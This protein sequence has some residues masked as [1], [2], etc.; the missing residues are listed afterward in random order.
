MY[1]PL[2]KI[3]TITIQPESKLTKEDRAFVDKVYNEQDI[4]IDKMSKFH[5]TINQLRNGDPDIDQLADDFQNSVKNIIEN[6]KTNCIHSVFKYFETKYNISLK[7]INPITMNKATGELWIPDLADYPQDLVDIRLKSKKDIL[8]LIFDE[9]GGLS[10]NEV[11][12]QN[13]IN[14]CRKLFKNSSDYEFK[15][16]R[17]SL[18]LIPYFIRH[19]KCGFRDDMWR[20]HSS[21]IKETESFFTALTHLECGMNKVHDKLWLYTTDK[22]NLD[23]DTLF[24]TQTFDFERIKALRFFKNGWLQIWFD[25]NATAERF[26]SVYMGR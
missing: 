2:E 6:A 17:K 7:K 12:E 4:I 10:F 13:I 26:K 21:W 22:I 23:N 25:S 19:I 16:D 18:K 11:L 24:K 14:S 9:L 5:P 3:M 15:I 20:L 1:D 8:N